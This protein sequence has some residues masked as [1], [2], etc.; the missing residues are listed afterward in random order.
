MYVL[1][2]L[3]VRSHKEEMVK[4]KIAPLEQDGEWAGE[5]VGNVNGC[6]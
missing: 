4:S 2:Y 3:G 5:S 1:S 6:K